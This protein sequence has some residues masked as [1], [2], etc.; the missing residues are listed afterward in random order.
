MM[1][2]NKTSALGIKY[3][4]MFPALVAENQR[5]NTPSQT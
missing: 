3:T 1:S 2:K 5:C 4:G